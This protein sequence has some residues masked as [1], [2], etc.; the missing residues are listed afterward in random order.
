MTIMSTKYGSKRIALTG[1]N[2]W[3]KKGEWRTGRGSDVEVAT[4]IVIT[5]ALRAGVPGKQ[6][7]YYSSDAFS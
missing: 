3:W 7:H 6:V 1:A 2:D 5:V 4:P